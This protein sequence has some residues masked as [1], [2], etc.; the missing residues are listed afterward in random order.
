LHTV[1]NNMTLLSTQNY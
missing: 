1:L